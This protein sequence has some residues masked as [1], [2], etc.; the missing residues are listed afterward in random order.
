V[1]AEAEESSGPL[2]R[3]L[4]PPLPGA[5][6][7]MLCWSRMCFARASERVNDLSHSK[8][9][10][11]K[12]MK[13]KINEFFFFEEWTRKGANL[14]GLEHTKGFSPVCDRIWDIK[15]NLEVWGK[16]RR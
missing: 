16:P 5:G 11:L 8:G 6:G 4:L 10:S 12:G 9:Q 14:P 13:A 7:S 1:V 2:L 3:F 15:A